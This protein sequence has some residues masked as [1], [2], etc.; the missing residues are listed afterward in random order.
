MHRPAPRPGLVA[1]ASALVLAVAGCA[2]SDPVAS[3]P[4]P[5]S[6]AAPDRT[7][8]ASDTTAVAADHA[9][10]DV[11]FSGSPTFRLADG[12]DEKGLRRVAWFDGKAPLRSGWAWGQEHLDG[13]VAVAEAPV[14]QGRLVMCGPQVL[15]RG[16]PH[17]TF[18]L[19]FNGIVQAG[20][21]Q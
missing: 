1:V 20:V 15:F 14:G 3:P 2:G 18:K 10:A 17:G 12:A 11:M 16:Q 9:D 19:L 6:T 4:A 7:A 5:P 13:G 8:A 21:K